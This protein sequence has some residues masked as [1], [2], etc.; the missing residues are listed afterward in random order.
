MKVGRQA[1]P[2]IDGDSNGGGG[3]KCLSRSVSVS[4]SLTVTGV[5]TLA[6]Y[7]KRRT[8]VLGETNNITIYLKLSTYTLTNVSSCASCCHENNSIAM[9]F[10][11]TY[12]GKRTMIMQNWTLESGGASGRTRLASFFFNN[13][14]SE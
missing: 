4:A 5:Q 11:C 12:Q 2:R 7:R 9:C 14:A 13:G 8:Y 1:T 3:F 6:E 10:N